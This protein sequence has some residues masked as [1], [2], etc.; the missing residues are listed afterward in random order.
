VTQ[1]TAQFP[2]RPDTL[3]TLRDVGLIVTQV[4]SSTPA[5]KLT[6]VSMPGSTEGTQLD[7]WVR[8]LST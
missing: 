1:P 5:A 6:V 7:G 4:E 3:R 8:R 2:Q